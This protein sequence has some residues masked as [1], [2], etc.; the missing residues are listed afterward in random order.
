MINRVFEAESSV[1]IRPDIGEFGYYNGGGVEVL[2]II[3][4]GYIES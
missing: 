4:E 3:L 1:I 2:V